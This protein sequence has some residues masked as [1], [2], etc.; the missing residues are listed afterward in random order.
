[1]RVSVDLREGLQREAE[2]I[3]RTGETDVVQGRRNIA[4]LAF[5]LGIGSRRARLSLSLSLNKHSS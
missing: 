1:M 3:V 5:I 2:A 4:R